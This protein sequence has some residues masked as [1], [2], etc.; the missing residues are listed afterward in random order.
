MNCK[1]QRRTV[2]PSDSPWEG[3]VGQFAPGTEGG[4]CSTVSLSQKESAALNPTSVALF[5]CGHTVGQVASLPYCSKDPEDE[6][7][8]LQK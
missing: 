1:L 7:K 2:V 4:P 8:L 5:S 3:L 6:P